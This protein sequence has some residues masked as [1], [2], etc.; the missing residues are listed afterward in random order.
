M[1]VYL[2]LDDGPEFRLLKRYIRIEMVSEAGIYF[3]HFKNFENRHYP[4]STLLKLVSSLHFN[5]FASF[6]FVPCVT[7]GFHFPSSDAFFYFITKSLVDAQFAFAHHVHQK[8]FQQQAH[9]SVI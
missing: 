3:T 2:Q 6:A 5:S 9:F 4:L 8:R 7:D 1:T